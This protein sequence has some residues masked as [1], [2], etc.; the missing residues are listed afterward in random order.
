M[1]EHQ[2]E[3]ERAERAF[4]ERDLELLRKILPPLIEQNNAAAIRISSSFFAAGTSDEECDRIYVEGMF[5]AAELGDLKAKYQVGIFYDLGEYDIP[6]DKIRASY[7]FKEL[8]DLGFPQCMWIHAC[9]L[10]WG[11]GPFPKSTESG[12]KLLISAADAGAANA[13]M[14]IARLHSDGELGLEKSTEQRDK[15]RKLAVKYDA[16]IYDPYA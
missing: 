11:S 12:L 3:I 2:V 10:I 4:E 13:C 7:I 15:F 8:A 14:T 5:R 1:N 9:E 6:Q 16:T